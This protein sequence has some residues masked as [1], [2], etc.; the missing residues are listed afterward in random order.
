MRKFEIKNIFLSPLAYIERHWIVTT[1]FIRSCR[2]RYNRVKL[3][4][5][6]VCVCVCECVCECMCECVWVCVSVCESLCEC[7]CV[8]E[9]VCECVW[10][11]VS[12]CVC[13]MLL[14]VSLPVPRDRQIFIAYRS[15][16]A[17]GF[18]GIWKIISGFFFLEKNGF[19]KTVLDVRI[20]QT[21]WKS[22]GTWRLECLFA[23]ESLVLNHKE[24]A[25][26]CGYR[27]NLT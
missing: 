15:F 24:R 10:E 11:C 7:M 17:A 25:W 16:H 2:W 26:R 27:I 13:V 20:W 21:F 6:L 5:V 3:Y 18:C 14:P 1:Q 9:C 8:C 19:V 4:L 22:G 23:D 12:V